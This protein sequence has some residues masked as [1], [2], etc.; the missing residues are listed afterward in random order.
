M[1][2]ASNTSCPAELNSEK[3]GCCPQ[4]TNRSPLGR[5]W[6]PPSKLLFSPGLCSNCL[7]SVTVLLFSFTDNSI[8]RA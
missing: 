1:K 8:A 6:A 4:P 2:R 5:I 3:Y 7:T